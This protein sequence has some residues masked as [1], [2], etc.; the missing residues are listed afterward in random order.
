MFPRGKVP[1]TAGFADVLAFRGFEGADEIGA[2]TTVWDGLID[3]LEPAL[4]VAEFAPGLCLAAKGRLPLMALG[5]GFTPFNPNH[6]PLR[7]CFLYTKAG[8]IHSG[9]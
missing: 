2:I 8:L 9:W 5:N 4:A 6:F 7:L 3:A 1:P